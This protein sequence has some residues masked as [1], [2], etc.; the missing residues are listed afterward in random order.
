LR[1][2]IA[3]ATVLGLVGCGGPTLYYNPNLE[4]E[5]VQTQFDIDSARCLSVAHGAAPLP[6]PRRY[7]PAHTGPYRFTADATTLNADGSRSQTSYSGTVYQP[8]G[9]F[10]SG[11]NQGFQNGLEIGNALAAQETRNRI[12]GGCLSGLGWTTNHVAYVQAFNARKER[13]A[14]LVKRETASEPPASPPFMATTGSQGDDPDTISAII[15]TIPELAEWRKSDEQ[16]WNM[17]VAIDGAMLS[18]PAYEKISS[19]ERFLLVVEK[20]KQVTSPAPA[21]TAVEPGALKPITQK[22]FE[23]WGK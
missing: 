10:Y 23:N 7:D 15:D 11:V 19:R 16:R 2:L 4:N 22:D 14:K 8:S 6:P 1:L 12:W 3:V 20:V 9:G 18:D 13:E 5:V 21:R 17:A